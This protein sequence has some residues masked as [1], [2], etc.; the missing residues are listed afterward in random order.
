MYL[1]QILLPLRDNQNH[2]LPHDEYRTVRTELT[3]RFGGLTAF[4][5]APA[6]G[7]WQSGADVS[8]ARDDIVIFEVMVTDFDRSWWSGYRKDLE[9]RF[10]Q[11][12]VIIRAMPIELI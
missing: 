5:R 1:L 7:V 8:T 12:V 3:E 4:T 2:P 6:E 11:D 10:R 9:A